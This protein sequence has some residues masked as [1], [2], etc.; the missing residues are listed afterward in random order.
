MLCSGDLREGS[1]LFPFRTEKLSS[2]LAMILFIGESSFS[3]E[4][5][6]HAISEYNQKTRIVYYMGFLICDFPKNR[7]A[8]C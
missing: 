7:V 2:L 4:L 1:H 3:P 5:S 8:Q 6:I